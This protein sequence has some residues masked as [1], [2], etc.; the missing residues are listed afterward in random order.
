LQVHAQLDCLLVPNLR[1]ESNRMITPN[2]SDSTAQSVWQVRVAQLYGDMETFYIE[3]L[4]PFMTQ[5]SN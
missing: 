1:Q 5:G 3:L 2:N 4:L